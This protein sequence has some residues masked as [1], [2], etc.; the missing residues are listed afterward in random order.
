MG[1]KTIQYCETKNNTFA[2]IK[3]LVGNEKK[4]IPLHKHGSEGEVNCRQWD[5]KKGDYI[6]EFSYTWNKLTGDVI[7]I[8]INTQF[9]DLRQIGSG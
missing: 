3:I 2:S 9:N 4:T 6:R 1:V 8:E 5:F 7:K